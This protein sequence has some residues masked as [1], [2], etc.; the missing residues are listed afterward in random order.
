[1]AG[2]VMTPYK[3]FKSFTSKKHLKKIYETNIKN[4]PAVGLDKLN[5]HT[6]SN[7]L[8]NEI[9]VIHRK[10]ENKTYHFTTYKQKLISKGANKP[11]RC[12]SIPTI[13]DRITLKVLCE[14]L[15]SIY[16]SKIIQEIP[17]KKN[18]KNQ[19]VATIR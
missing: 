18:R 4:K 14:L 11:P 3:L 12:I 8:D 2:M 16:K 19:R 13:R 9:D 1:M 15:Q 17:Q 10:I 5:N 6:F 7:R